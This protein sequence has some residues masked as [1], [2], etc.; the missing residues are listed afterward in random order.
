M[1]GIETLTPSDQ[2]NPSLDSEFYLNVLR[3]FRE[4]L[5]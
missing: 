2:G 1:K 5:C 3:H 4:K